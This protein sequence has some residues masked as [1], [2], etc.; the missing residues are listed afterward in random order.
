MFTA[1]MVLLFSGCYKLNHNFI[2]KGK[3]YV[4]SFSINGGNTNLMDGV[5]PQYVVGKSNYIV[6]MLDDGILR[7]EYYTPDVSGNDSLVYY[8]TGVWDMPH[9]DSVYFN[10]DKF[11]N[12]T[13]FIEL[14]PGSKQKAS[15]L[16]SEANDIE[17]FDLGVVKSVMR[18][19]RGEWVD[20]ETT[21]P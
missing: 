13:F 3:W 5:L 11:I 21:K 15:L 12:G 4:N 16:T 19:S 7:G 1:V 18:I 17:F 9:K 6:Y 14:V 2:M 10:I 20:P 8:R